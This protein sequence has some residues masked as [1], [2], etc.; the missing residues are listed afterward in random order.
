MPLVGVMQSR[1][2]DSP[3]ISHASKFVELCLKEQANTGPVGPHTYDMVEYLG[4]RLLA[5]QLSETQKEQ[6]G[7]TNIDMYF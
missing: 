6:L 3:K 5:G 2:S 4:D 7:Y 1:E